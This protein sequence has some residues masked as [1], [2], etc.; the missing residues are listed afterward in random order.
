LSRRLIEAQERERTRI[1]R[2]LH[3]DIGQ[4]IALL[5]MELDHPKHFSDFGVE[6][7][8]YIDNLRTRV[9]E[10]G[11]Q[12]QAISHRLHSSKLEY[13]GLVAATKSF[14][15]ELAEQHS[16][17]IEFTSDGVPF[18]L[19]QDLSICLFRILQEALTNAV[20][21]SGVKDFQVKLLGAGKEIQLTVRD[22]GV[23]FDVEA[24][25]RKQGIG[26]ISMQE[27]VSLARGTISI[28]SEPTRGTE[29]NVRVPLCE[30]TESIQAQ[31]RSSLN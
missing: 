12:V 16:V 26:L 8:S 25:M 19:R 24:A 4:Q 22:S 28:V 10:I 15:N 14:C 31:G 7:Q 17:K 20:K 23:A 29:V 5:A 13:L 21:H 11:T 9:L 1:A 3:D 6:F 18:T 27:R 30:V 2:E